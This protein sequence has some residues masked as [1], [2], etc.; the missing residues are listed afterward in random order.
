MQWT[1]W[2]RLAIIT[3]F[4]VLLS[5]ASHAQA[6][7]GTI[8]GSVV[9]NTGAAIPGATITI[10]DTNKGTS[11]T[12]TAN[13]AGE[14]TVGHLIPDT[15]DISVTNAGF[16]TF[17]S[18]GLQVFADQSI[19]VEAKMEV[20]GASQTVT[21]SA[22]TVEQLKT[23]RADVSTTFTQQDVQDLPIGNRNFTNLQ[24][25][26]PGA[27]QLGWSHAADENPQGSQQIQVDGQAF[28]GV[29]YM[30]DGTDNQDPILGI[31]VINPNIDS[32]SETKI[33]TQNFD[34][35][36]GKAVSSF[37]TVQTKSG[38]NSFH[39]SAF[40]YRESNANV[41]TN[42]Y[43][44][45]RAPGATNN[46]GLIPG[47]LRSQ[48]GGSIGGPILK[49]KLWFFG[50][51]QLVR[52]K[53][54]TSATMSVPTATVLN[55]CLGKQVDMG[56]PGCDFNEYVSTGAANGPIYEADGKTPY[57]NNIIPAAQLSQPALN[58]LTL[59]AAYPANKANSTYTSLINQYAA[60][61]TGIFNSQQWDE[62]IDYQATQSIHAFERFSRFTDVLS[63]TT[64]FGP[65]GGAGFGINNYGGTSQGANDSV[66]AGMDWAVKPNIAM[67]LRGGY[68]RYNIG[69]VKY[70]EGT[71]FMSNL[72]IPGMNISSISS[73]AGG[74]YLSDAGNFGTSA[75]VPE[76]QSTGAQYGQGLQITRCNCPLIEREDQYQIVNNWTIIKG[77]HSFKV[78]ADLRYARNLR[79]PSDVDRTG[80]LSFGN[81]P[82]SNGT[83]GGT[84]LASLVLGD[85]TSFGR[86]FSD[87]TNAKEFQKRLFFYGQ[88]TWRITPKLTANLGLRYELYFPEVVNGAGNGALMQMNNAATTDGYLRV[89]GVGG[90]GTNMGWSPASNAWNPRIGL[91]YQVN[92]KTVVR[93]G[94]GRS[95]DLGVFGSIFGHTV[96]QNLPVLADQQITAPGS[97]FGAAATVF[98]LTSG[99]P[100]CDT[101][102]GCIP[103][104]PSNGLVPN[105]GYGVTVKARPNG[106][107]LP[108][109][110]AWN[111]SLQQSLT[112]TLSFTI[113]YV[114]N[115]GTHTLSDGDGNSTN[116]NEAGINLPAQYS[117]E[118][119]GLHYV[120]G[121]LQVNPDA[122]GIDPDGGV[123]NTLLLQ[124][125]Y[126]GSVAA[127]TDANYPYVNG[128]LPR[129]AGLPAGACGWVPAIQFNG[130]DQDTH[131]NA[132]QVTVAKQFSKGLSFTGNFGW[133]QSINF[134]SG[135][136]TWNK[137]AVRGLDS[138][139]RE[140]QFI[141]YGIYQLPFGRNAQFFSN[142]NGWVNGIIGGWQLSPIVT[143]AS[144]LPYQLSYSGCNFSV[145]GSA[146]C[147]PNGNGKTLKTHLGSF[148]PVT[149][150]RPYYNGATT[151][152]VQYVNGGLQYTPFSGFS[153]PGLDQIG[154]AGRNNEFGPTF[155]NTDL[156]LQKNVPIHESITGQFRVDAYNAFN[157]I[158]AGNPSG[159]IDSGP[160]AIGSIS[161]QGGTANLTRLLQFS[162]RVQ[163]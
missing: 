31:I 39:G 41:A 17:E 53:V 98:N 148:N 62:R 131:F 107:R 95:F 21:V 67:D 1:K 102:T 45:F 129:P 7:Y 122:N 104:V 81:G 119:R 69:D 14:F 50:D 160:Q 155:F 37:I 100:P 99:P 114:G 146:P 85:V 132:L 116:P 18:K 77:N 78:G 147:Y 124:R 143:W 66:A 61:G 10:T 161:G 25:L 137:R 87:S 118:G 133:Q 106:M 108:T 82:T 117:I 157:I 30:L 110:D 126:G 38:T 76:P 138:S 140:K 59:L 75:T 153:A 16:K 112:P 43:T 9:D 105:P 141:G 29:A 80:A 88:D 34:A 40:D 42:P 27:Q 111:A 19:K 36:F 64:I 72:G 115:K 142:V 24:L 47:G 55:T 22:T 127:C 120:P 70:N 150:N 52:Q 163:F 32:L 93:A 139:N 8:F 136:A 135:Y 101:A 33:T 23:D 162:L 97:Q 20:G 4:A 90:I 154:T 51:A 91:A 94:Y 3:A 12:A 65:A 54:G 86:Y 158:N 71:P 74:F 49:D 134:A 56:I 83:S 151:P 103:A 144:G 15:Y 109:L 121:V 128:S 123:S 159:A 63:G 48:F 2:G 60:S 68:Y 5:T 26:L 113:A 58:L 11:V 96:T 57:P 73:G 152:L 156:S 13:E 125:Y 92:P 46:D 35:E 28:G 145:P 89:A 130:D 79:V 84:G 149:H 44:Q 6:V